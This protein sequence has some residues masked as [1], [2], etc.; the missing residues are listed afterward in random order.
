VK[1]YVEE[2]GTEQVERLLHSG[3][4]ATCRLSEAEISAALARRYRAGELRDIDWMAMIGKLRSDLLR[5]QVVELAPAVV[6]RVHSLLERHALRTGDALHLAAAIA[7]RESTRVAIEF[8]GFDDR[9][10]GAARIEGFTVR[11]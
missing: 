3:P 7:L 4:G 2:R 8:V 6:S 10:N 9:L 1:R 11:P 5:L